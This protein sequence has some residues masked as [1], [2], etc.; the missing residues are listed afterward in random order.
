M[1]SNYLSPASFSINIER[2]PE[3]ELQC[4]K[5]NIPGVSSGFINTGSPLANLNYSGGRLDYED[6]ALSFLVQ[7]NMENY[8]E[9]FDWFIGM[10]SPQK[11]EQY[12][13]FAKGK[14]IISDITITITNSHKNPNMKIN[15]V[16]CFPTALSDIQLDVTAQDIE[17]PEATVN[18]KYDYFTIER[19]I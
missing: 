1:Y 18:F 9:I 2:I 8:L 4:Q 13:K 16:D 10:N 7:E 12:L 17:Y 3:C 19:L 5:I 15:F 6:L 14:K 11:S